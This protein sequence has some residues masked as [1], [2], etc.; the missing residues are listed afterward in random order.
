MEDGPDAFAL[1]R[2]NSIRIAYLENNLDADDVI[3]PNRVAEES[4]TKEKEAD[5]TSHVSNQLKELTKKLTDFADRNVKERITNEKTSQLAYAASLAD[6]PT[7]G[8][9]FDTS[10]D[11]RKA[12]YKRMTPRYSETHEGHYYGGSADADAE[13]SEATVPRGKDR[14]DS[15]QAPGVTGHRGQADA[16]AGSSLKFEAAALVPPYTPYPNP[17]LMDTP[18]TPKGADVKRAAEAADAKQRKFGVTESYPSLPQLVSA[19]MGAMVAGEVAGTWE[20]FGGLGAQMPNLAEVMEVALKTNQET[21]A[22]LIYEQN[23]EWQQ[24]A[25]GRRDINQIAVQLRQP[26][27]L[28]LPRAIEDQKKEFPNR[29]E[30]GT[31]DFKFS[32]KKDFQKKGGGPQGWTQGGSAAYYKKPDGAQSRDNRDKKRQRGDRQKDKGRDSPKYR[33]RPDRSRSRKKRKT[34]DD[35]TK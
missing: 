23:Q 14:R 9:L 12:L 2:Q 19:Q 15:G 35:E 26:N 16:D 11:E 20:K 6:L 25:R 29:A 28:I 21:A 30:K 27:Q 13:T 32:G 24:L 1:K 3:M 18:W 4:S 22:K 33:F 5:E 31:K 17:K 10:D 7:L 8:T 34:A